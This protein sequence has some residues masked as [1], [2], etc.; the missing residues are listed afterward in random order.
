MTASIDVG[1]I[2][3]TIDDRLFVING[4]G[5]IFTKGIDNATPSTKGLGTIGQAI[6][7]EVL[8]LILFWNLGCCQDAQGA[9]VQTERLS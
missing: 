6:A 1:K 9:G 8:R 5:D 7:V 2:D 4:S 3:I